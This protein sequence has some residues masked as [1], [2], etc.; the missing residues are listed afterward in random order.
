MCCIPS[1]A[2]LCF[3]AVVT[4]FRGA[5]IL[6][7]KFRVFIYFFYIFFPFV[8]SSEVMMVSNFSIAIRAKLFFDPVLKFKKPC[9]C[10]TTFSTFFYTRELVSVVSYFELYF[11]PRNSQ[12]K[13]FFV[14]P[15][16]LNA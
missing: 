9:F 3:S 6:S 11:F 7:R 15:L 10:Y 2:M 8:G 12:I 1:N 4:F 16:L 13:V 14:V 5:V